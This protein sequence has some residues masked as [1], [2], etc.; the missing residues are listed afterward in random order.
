MASPTNIE[1]VSIVYGFLK[2]HRFVSMEE[3]M[4]S[5]RAHTGVKAPRADVKYALDILKK[6]KILEYRTSPRPGSSHLNDDYFRLTGVL[7][8]NFEKLCENG[9]ESKLT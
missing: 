7:P 9:L 5:Y 4:D 6:L 8:K 1:K 2:V 3:L